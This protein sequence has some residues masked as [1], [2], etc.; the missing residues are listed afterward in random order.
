MCT[1][2]SNSTNPSLIKHIRKVSF[3]NSIFTCL[4]FVAVVKWTFSCND[5]VQKSIIS[6]CCGTVL[7]IKKVKE[8]HCVSNETCVSINY[9]QRLGVYEFIIMN[10]INVHQNY[11]NSATLKL[12]LIFSFWPTRGQQRLKRKRKPCHNKPWYKIVFTQ[13]TASFLHVAPLPN[14]FFFYLF[15]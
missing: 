11:S 10:H 14:F 13:Q 7:A 5:R 1:H 4:Y 8:L 12:Q 9:K 15:H 3:S 6:W 2:R